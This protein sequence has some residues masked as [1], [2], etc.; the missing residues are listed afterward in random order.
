MDNVIYKQAARKTGVKWRRKLFF[1]EKVVRDAMSSD[2]NMQ[3]RYQRQATA[4][5]KRDIGNKT[6]L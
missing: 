6:Q 1:E 4:D 5:K 2:G 3:W